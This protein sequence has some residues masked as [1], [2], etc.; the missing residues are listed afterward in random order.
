MMR[1]PLEYGQE[2]AAAEL[3]IRKHKTRFQVFLRRIFSV[4]SGSFLASEGKNLMEV[5]YA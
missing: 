1:H 3:S 2:N 5:S 4:P